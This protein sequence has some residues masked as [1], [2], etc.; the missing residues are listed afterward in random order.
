M[1]CM[2]INS[3]PMTPNRLVFIL[4]LVTL[5]SV[6]RGQQMPATLLMDAKIVTHNQQVRKAGNPALAAAYR[7]LMQ[8]A[9]Q[10][11]KNN[12]VYSVMDKIPLPPS[13]DKH[14]YMSQAPY[15]WP[16]PT[17]ADGKPYIR[18]DGDRNPEINGI[19]DHDHFDKLMAESE[20]LGLA[21]FYSGEEKYAEFGAKLLKTWFL[22]PETRMN[23]HLKYG[24]GIPGVNNGRGI[25]IIET[26][27]LG[28]V[29]DASALLAGSKHWDGTAQQEL[30][31]WFSS[32]L[33]WLMT[34]DLGK[35]E[36]DEHNNHGTYYDVQLVALALACGRRDLAEKQLTVTKQRMASQWK[37]DGSQ[38]HELARTL[39]WNYTNM[40]L[41]GFM[42]LARLAEHLRI[43]LWTYETPDGKGIRKCVDFLVPFVEGQKA[44]TYQQIK[45][46]SYE[47]SAA[48][49]TLASQKYHQ[50]A[51]LT[52]LPS[53]KPE[54]RNAFMLPLLLGTT[55]KE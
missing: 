31:K 4:L 7:Q 20:L 41:W 48:I 43:D 39:S 22:N 47:H 35:D 3:I 16:D 23:P 29:C 2:P 1:V 50:P 21:Y 5:Y 54:G 28:K 25:G 36:A 42:T 24:Q 33:E 45:P 13:G 14:D 44:W 32:Y 52:L 10:L 18:R 19:T 15:W 11:V 30:N 40:N 17:K 37:P 27:E 6:V 49:F 46:K 53:V 12:K 51:Y 34:S 55:S 9:D 38:P 8:E 26:R